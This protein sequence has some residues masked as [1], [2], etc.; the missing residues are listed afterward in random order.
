M[1]LL[2][3]ALLDP[4]DHPALRAG[5]RTL[6]YRDLLAVATAHAERI[7]T[8]DRVAVHAAPG[9]HTA[10]AVVSA[11]L[12][13]VP[14]VP[15]NPKLGERELAH[16][17]GDAKPAAVLAAPGVELGAV[18]GRVGR[19]D[20]DLD[21]RSAAPLPAEHAAAATALIVYTS[22][23]TGPPKGAVL[24]RGAIAANLDALAD[25][26]AWTGGDV[27][28]H[29]LPLFH[30]H[31]LVLGVL[32]P[33]RRG[34]TLHHLP[35]LDAAGLAAAVDGGATMVFGVPTQYHR[36][37]DQLDTD[38]AAARTIG[39]ARLLVS[40][41]AALT[42]VDHERI[43][44]AT[45]LAVRERY[46]LTE[47]LI[48]TAARADEEPEPGTVG[49]PLAGTEVRLVPV[50]GDPDLGTVEARGPG[51]FDGYLDRPD[52]TAATR[53]PDGWFATGDIGRWTPSGALALV[54]RKAIDL[55]KSGGYKIGAGE[56][57]NALLEHPGVAEAAVFGTPDDDLGERVVA[58]VVAA[59]ER[60][61]AQELIDHVATL[62][63]P[64]KRPRDVRFVDVL[65]RNDMG[66]V[67][68]SRLRGG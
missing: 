67:L 5:G 51:L 19:I 2:L 52:A 33:L 42:A 40:G 32:G 64:H 38:P 25:A 21:A 8:L 29:A 14:A 54:G 44:R 56:I 9:P 68:K 27:L 31:G 58:V 63:S 53:T 43:Q 65:P 10:V 55:I 60:P 12:A 26:W 4:S 24:S 18:A 3:P 59:G 49:R 30:V 1:S 57:E 45:G 46:G 17:V 16:V 23:T 20:I 34:G 41:S 50:D 61:A 47:S 66:K 37:A 15:L 48:L 22:G 36:L 62:L 39:R 35:A 13:G 28:A 11:L 6:T 7:R